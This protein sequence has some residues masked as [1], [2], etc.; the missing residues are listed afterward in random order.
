M[1]KTRLIQFRVSGNEYERIRN[2]AH[3]KGYSTIASYLRSVA[4]GKDLFTETNITEIHRM[5]KEILDK[6]APSGKNPKQ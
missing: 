2:N 6:N 1:V 4:L 5:V 3:A